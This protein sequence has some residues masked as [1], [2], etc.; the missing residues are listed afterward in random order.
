MIVMERESDEDRQ[1]DRNTVLEPEHIREKLFMITS[2]IAKRYEGRSA[3]CSD[4][5]HELCLVP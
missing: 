4:S 2:E 1:A 5:D 3:E